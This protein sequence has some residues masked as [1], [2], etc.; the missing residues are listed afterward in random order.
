[1][2]ENVL[3]GV[4]DKKLA[5]RLERDSNYTKMSNMKVDGCVQIF[6]CKKQALTELPQQFSEGASYSVNPPF[7]MSVIV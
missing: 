2:S 3:I 1:M 4:R 5:Q 7:K 6:S